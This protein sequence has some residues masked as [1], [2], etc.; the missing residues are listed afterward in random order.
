MITLYLSFFQQFSVGE[1]VNLISIDASRFHNLFFSINTTWNA[2]IIISMSLYA[3][4]NYLG[5]S[6]LAGL[7]VIVALVPANAIIASL[8]KK[9]Q[10]L[11]MK[12]K[13]KR[14]KV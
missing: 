2:P 13:D 7:A 12:L 4:W 11:L 9:R 6:C 3:L 14:I 8:F 10:M 1:T 5:P